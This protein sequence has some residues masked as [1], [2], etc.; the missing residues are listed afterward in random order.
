[1]EHSIPLDILSSLQKLFVGYIPAAI[2][3]GFIG[4][5]ISLNNPIYQLSKRIF[6]IPHSIPPIAL[7]PISLILFPDSEVASVM[8]IFIGTLWT[9]ILNM[10][11]GMGHF[12]RQNKSFRAA[13][14]HT[15]HA[16][17]V[18]IWVAWFTVIA[19]EMLVGPKGLGLLVWDAYKAGN[20]S[21]LIQAIIYIGVIGCLL[22]QFLDF[23]TYLLVQ[24]VS[25]SKKSS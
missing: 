7:L 4:Y 20:V 24:M 9:M 25:G 5:L 14:F 18:S 1:M 23:S 12:Y 16:L 2:L 22:D 21:Y 17:K 3:G 15:F 6:Q 19:I 11:I 8:V 13:I 10:A